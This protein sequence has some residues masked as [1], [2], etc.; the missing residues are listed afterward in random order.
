MQNQTTTATTERLGHHQLRTATENKSQNL[1]KYDSTEHT[2]KK[3]QITVQ[4]LQGRYLAI[5]EKRSWLPSLHSIAGPTTHLVE[6]KPLHRQR[7]HGL[8][9]LVMNLYH[10]R[11]LLVR[12]VETLLRRTHAASQS[13]QAM[14]KATKPKAAHFSQEQRVLHYTRPPRGKEGVLRAH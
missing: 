9:G 13:A 4:L 2:Q 7:T 11:R 14:V 12:D 5:S 6:A 1:T 3:Q 10:V 8:H